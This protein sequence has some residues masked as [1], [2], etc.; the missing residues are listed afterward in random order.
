MTQTTTQ[1]GMIVRGRQSFTY[2][3]WY[4]KCVGCG[5]IEK[6]ENEITAQQRAR[7]HQENGK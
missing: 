4:L 6:A 5:W 1:V 7:R 2:P 3:A